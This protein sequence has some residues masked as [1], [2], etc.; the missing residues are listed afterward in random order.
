MP[1]TIILPLRKW[2]MISAMGSHQT[3]LEGERKP[4][5]KRVK[6]FLFPWEKPG[7]KPTMIQN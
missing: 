4:F 3:I 1:A 7:P 6:T 5:K 2:V